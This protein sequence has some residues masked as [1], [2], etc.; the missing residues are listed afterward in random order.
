MHN[1]SC[2]IEIYNIVLISP[3][4]AYGITFQYYHYNHRK[5]LFLVKNIFGDVLQYYSIDCFE[6][7]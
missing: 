4:F 7:K 6:N 3:S 1:K 5:R 2:L